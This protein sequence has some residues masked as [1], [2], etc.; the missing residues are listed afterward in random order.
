MDTPNSIKKFRRYS[1]LAGLA[2]SY[3]GMGALAGICVTAWFLCSDLAWTP[4][5]GRQGPA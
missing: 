1:L 5:L 2:L 3:F 4:L